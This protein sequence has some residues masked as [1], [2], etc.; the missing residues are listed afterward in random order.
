LLTHQCTAGVVCDRCVKRNQRTQIEPGLGCDRT[1]LTELKSIFIPDIINKMHESQALKTFVGEHIG[2]WS[3]SAIKLKFNC[4]WGL[5]PLEL[6][7][8]EFEPRTMELLSKVEYF[9]RNNV[10]EFVE[11]NSPPLGMVHIEDEDRQKYDRYLN[12]LVDNHLDKFA[13]RAFKF[14]KD[15]FQG[16]LLKLM[17]RLQP[18]QKDEV[19]LTGN[20]LNSVTDTIYSKRCCTIFSGCKL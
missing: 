5:P 6:E 18:E 10:Q 11:T 1:K 12:K 20:N 17:V 7:V 3:G 2:R 14:E 9:T 4:I 15:D 19:C 8:Y 16:R 13:S